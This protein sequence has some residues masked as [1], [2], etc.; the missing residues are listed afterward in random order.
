MASAQVLKDLVYDVGMHNGDDTA[1]Y[2]HQA[3]RV[4]A[5]EADPQLVDAARRRFGSELTSGRLTILNVGVAETEGTGTFWVCEGVSEWNSF[6]EKVSSRLGEKHHAIEI[7]TRP[8]SDI[9]DEYGVPFY[10]KVDIEGNDHL[11][12]RCLA[13]RLLPPFISVEAENTGDNEDL[14]EPEALENL[15][16]LYDAG[17]RRFKLI[18]QYDF[19]PVL[20]SDIAAFSRRILNSAVNGRL[21]APGLSLLAKRLTYKDWLL[22]KHRY[23]FPRESSGPWG[24]VSGKVVVI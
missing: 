5:I 1:F 19:E 17:Y 2:L 18:S 8:F 24:E 12:I 7:E 3:F 9:L 16:L 14:S 6:Y 23:Q 10:L 11:C 21:R 20:Y 13:G 22:R 15:S 4:I